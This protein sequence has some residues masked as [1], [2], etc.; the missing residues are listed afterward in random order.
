MPAPGTASTIRSL[1]GQSAA[2]HRWDSPNKDD[3]AR[4]YAAARIAAYVERTVSSAPPLTTEQRDKLALL[5]RGSGE[6]V[7][8]T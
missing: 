5:L 8:A 2:A 7:S 4:E 3:L 6:D 1:Q